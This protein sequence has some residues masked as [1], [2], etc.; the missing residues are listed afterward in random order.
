MGQCEI[1]ST[2][3]KLFSTYKNQDPQTITN[4]PLVIYIS[5]SLN[6]ENIAA[7]TDN[8]LLWIGS[9]DFT[10]KYCEYNIGNTNRPKQIA[11]LVATFL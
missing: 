5:I 2:V 9:S 7:Y 4:L 3:D 8:G 10:K 1:I 11:W 6:G